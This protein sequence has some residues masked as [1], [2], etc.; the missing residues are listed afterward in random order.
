MSVVAQMIARAEDRW[1]TDPSQVPDGA[2]GQV[3]GTVRALQP[4][5]IHVSA[6][7]LFDNSSD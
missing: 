1:P 6:M 5:G 3:H 4:F 7:G 2:L